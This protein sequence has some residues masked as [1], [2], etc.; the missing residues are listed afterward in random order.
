M[1]SGTGEKRA[2]LR[3]GWAHTDPWNSDNPDGDGGGWV[4]C[5][6]A[7]A[8]ACACA[9]VCACAGA[10]VHAGVRDVFAIYDNII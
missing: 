10:C 9:R 2:Y 7:C 5:A 3:H 1:A 6:L 4:A 8:C